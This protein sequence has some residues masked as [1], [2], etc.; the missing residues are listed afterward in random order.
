MQLVPPRLLLLKGSLLLLLPCGFAPQH[1][2]QRSTLPSV[3][4]LEKGPTALGHSLV[5]SLSL[6]GFALAGRPQAPR[7]PSQRP[8]PVAG[9][10]ISGAG[11]VT[12]K[13]EQRYSGPGNGSDIARSL[14][15]DRAGNVYVTGVSKG[16]DKTYDYATLKYAANGNLLWEQ[17]YNGPGKSNDD[18]AALAV[19]GA[20]N[21]YVTGSS[22]GKDSTS[23]YAT[24]K[25]AANGKLL[26]EKRYNGPGKGEDIAR[27]LV[28]DGI[29][30]VYVTG[31]SKGTGNNSDYATLKYAPNGELLY[32]KRYN[33]PGN[34]FD[35]VEAL[36][37]DGAGN[38]YVTGNSIG[39][40]DD[41]DYATLKY[42][43][44]GELLWEQRYDGPSNSDDIAAALAVDG[45]GNVYIT[46]T[47]I[48]KNGTYD[49]ATLKYTAN[50]TLIW[51]KRYNGPGKSDDIA[52]ALAVD[53]S[54]SVCVTGA[55]AG[56]D[57]KAA[58]ATL[59]IAAN[60]GLSWNVRNSDYATIKYATT[61]ELLWEQRYNG[62][63]NSEDFAT[64]LTVDVAGNVY[65]AGS[66]GGIGSNSDYATLKYDTNGELL[67]EQR[68]NGP[69][70]GNDAVQ[71][72]AVDGASNAYAAGGSQGDGSGYDYALVK[73]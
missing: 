61:G 48:G 35:A 71:H 13:W 22:V 23:D 27:A 62:P 3:A 56:K 67:W 59:K 38:V 49:Y 16:N 8:Q 51:A 25:Y 54:G 39:K 46:G 9:W 60:G 53:G 24:L 73:Y 32:A 1:S 34:G 65:V 64:S 6:G 55:S 17:R 11:P 28:V 19:D 47:S 42:A 26:W 37:V 20:S 66:S 70:N 50:G 14:A 69:S 58:H 36:A 12:E 18:A 57:N 72:L 63:G 31:G 4:C 15:V 21:V 52:V 44:N 68:Y 33:G 29:G 7:A 43:P 5:T 30:N 45:A 10:P 41:A 2:P 40:D